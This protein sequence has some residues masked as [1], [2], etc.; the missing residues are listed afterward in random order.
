METSV[1][2]LF[3]RYEQSFNRSLHGKTDMDET[4]SFYASEFIAASPLGVMAGRNDE[5]LSQAMIQGYERYRTI[6]TKEMRIRD[7]RVV[8]ID[9]HHCVAHVAWTAIYIRQD[10]TNIS[11]DFDVHYLVQKLDDEPKISG[12]VSGD[13]N[14]ELRKHGVI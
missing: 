9:E 4:A 2:K 13:E 6:G 10:R 7:V 8:P 3:E 11:I 1:R 12:W 5:T 14:A